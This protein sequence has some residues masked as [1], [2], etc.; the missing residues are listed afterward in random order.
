MEKIY[1]IDEARQALKLWGE[2][3]NAPVHGSD[4]YGYPRQ[5]SI[6]SIGMGKRPGK[7]PV[8][9]MPSPIVQKVDRAMKILED[10][11]PIEYIALKYKY[12]YKYTNPDA[13]SAMNMAEK[14]YKVKILCALKFIAGNI[15]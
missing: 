6:V 7:G 4:C 3:Q 8:I 10:H 9:T 12:E 5:S 2:Y 14:T 11:E 15:S 13:A 1:S